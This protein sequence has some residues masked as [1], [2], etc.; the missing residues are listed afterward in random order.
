[1]RSAWKAATEHPGTLLVTVCV[2]CVALGFSLAAN[3]Y[4]HHSTSAVI[5][6]APS[7]SMPLDWRN[8]FEET[9]KRLEPS[10]V[11][12][13]SEKTEEVNTGMS[14]MDDFFNLGPF[15]GPFGNMR[16]APEVE[17]QTRTA[18][19]SGVIVRS[20]GYILTN[21]HVVADADRVTVKLTDGREFKGKV[22][23]DKS[24]DLAL[25]K[26]DAKDLPAAQFAD[27]D[28][29]RVGEWSMAIGNPFGLQNTVTVGVVSA[30][31]KD[32]NQGPY[33]E[34]I[35]TDASINPG[36]SGG[37]LV[38]LEGKVIGINGMIYSTSGGNVGIGFA[39][40]SNVAKFVM[41]QL[42]DKGK[43]VR[44]FLGVGLQDL[45][46]VIAQNY[47]VKQGALVTSVSP[48]SPAKKAGVEFK[49]IITK[50]NGKEVNNSVELRHAIEMLTPGT[51]VKLS[52]MRDKKEK[53]VSVKL[54]ERTD[55]AVASTGDVDTAKTGITVQ[56]LTSDIAQQL[57]MDADTKGVVVSKVEP[58]TPGA[59]AGLQKG[60]VIL[61]LD[62]KPVTS[63][64][65]FNKA[66]NGIKDSTVIVV[67]QRGDSRMFVE[68]PME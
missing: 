44:G 28:K 57:G 62:N 15:G 33:R 29:V 48:D 66:V 10:V 20:D 51:E 17:K 32:L 22:L 42:I 31:R 7:P 67:I 36:N 54:T 43:V 52:L 34:V 18:S 60:D 37:P 61:E 49:D 38:D 45:T 19:G 46:P 11:F 21:N 27:S 13:T 59:R 14:G 64:A 8:A 68:M 6:A 1:M 16:P 9:A 65:T 47:G 56:T 39:I 5:A 58:G 25:V 12:I 3:L 53:T 23:L 4:N 63:L 30:L 2:L 35:Q 50:V 24:T 26:I 55:S 41:S 40:P